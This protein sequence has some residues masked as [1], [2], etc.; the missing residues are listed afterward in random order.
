MASVVVAAS[1][2]SA[3]IASSI[4][5]VTVGSASAAQK[6][7]QA[8]P[9][10][11]CSR[12]HSAR[13]SSSF[14]GK[15]LVQSS[16]PASQS[17]ECVTVAMADAAADAKPRVLVSE[18][19]G[20]EGVQILERMGMVADCIYDLTPAQL[21][22][23]ISGYDALIVR[24]GTKVTKEVF[25][26]SKGSLKV[27]GRAGVG[28]DNVDLVAATEVGCLVV[29][30]PTANIMAA[31]EHGIALLTTVARN[32]PQA[33]TSLKKGEWKRNQFVGVSLADK[34]L[35]VIGFGKVG[36]EV[37]RRAKGLGMTVVAHD[38][39][40]SEDR[41]KAVGVRLV[42]FDEA[43][44]LGDFFSLHMPLTPATDKMFNDAA[45][46]K[47][48]HGAR[49]V[50]VARGGVI[51]EDALGRALDSGKVAAAALDVFTEEPPAKDHPLI[52]RANVLCT[53]HL[54][55][56][57]QEAQAGVAVEIAEAVAGALNGE[58][59][60]TAVNAPMVPAEVL[61][62]L[63]PYVKLAENLGRVAV[64]LVAKSGV[65]DV[66]ITYSTSRGDDLDTRLLRA[67]VIKGL[68]EPV[69]SA[70][71]NLVNADYLAKQRGLRIVEI[72][73]PADDGS[74]SEALLA[75]ICVELR[76]SETNFHASTIA[77]GAIAV[78]GKVRS[79]MPFLT[80]MGNFAV[81]V[82][83]EGNLLLTRQNDQPGIIGALG[84]RLG[85]AKVNIAFMSVSRKSANKQAVSALGVDGE[86][87]PAV[88]ASVRGI[89]AIDEVAFVKI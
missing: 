70:F 22:E 35:A 24:S 31:A 62:E 69:S 68:V 89:P 23:K 55:A 28:I 33:N 84:K 78:E 8:A 67:M 56:S 38:P 87:P 51:D 15:V 44:E 85:D 61:S 64:Q 49:I 17:Q 59:A 16:R 72:V 14:F 11:K 60:A 82:S 58:L 36:T 12:K 43:L 9:S 63:T 3:V 10:Q 86:V 27:V 76:G 75:K 40:A 19:L 46:A 7:R 20:K 47:I 13:C 18:K 42:S 81:D 83:M 52:K 77:D 79:G 88:M 73:E 2:S 41:A 71:V 29:N 21:C 80:R 66:K 32:I 5:R 50:N 48:K 45:F 74:G 1:S 25:Q 53:P 54:G 26:A 37:A 34:T 65:R 6:Q 57:T 4:G 30:A 39:Y